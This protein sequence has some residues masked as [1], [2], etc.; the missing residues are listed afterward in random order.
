MRSFCKLP[1]R[2]VLCEACGEL[3][4]PVISAGDSIM[5]EVTDEMLERC[6][7]DPL[8]RYVPERH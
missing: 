8:S 4:E 5:P 1:R 3:I 6:L 7:T 2:R